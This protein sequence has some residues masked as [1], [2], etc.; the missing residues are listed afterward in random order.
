MIS[1]FFILKVWA[2]LVVQNRFNP[3]EYGH[4]YFSGIENNENS[5]TFDVTGSL[6]FVAST[7]VMQGKA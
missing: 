6:W 7:F 3:Y 5:D 1:F 4:R 2:F